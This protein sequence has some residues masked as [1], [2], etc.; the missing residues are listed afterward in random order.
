MKNIADQTAWLDVSQTA[1]E[2][3]V[4]Q[5]RFFTSA[6][7]TAII[8]GPLR[9]YFSDR[10]ESEALQIYFDIQESLSKHGMQ[11]NGFPLDHPHTFLMLYPDK[12]S[13]SDIFEKDVEITEDRFGRHFVLGV[14]GPCEGGKRHMIS[15][16][17]CQIFTRSEV[18][19]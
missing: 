9:I 6:F 19:R 10:Q 16:H 8:D 4:T 13:F 15:G 5:S 3:V 17:V 18:V 14:N 12:Q 7:N 2:P 11:L 1:Q